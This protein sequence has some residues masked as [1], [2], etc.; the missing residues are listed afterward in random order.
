MPLME[1]FKKLRKSRKMTKKKE[2]LLYE[3]TL[4]LIAR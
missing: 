3:R 1:H 2:N 4:I